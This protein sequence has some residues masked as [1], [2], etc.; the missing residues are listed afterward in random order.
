MLAFYVHLWP[1]YELLQKSVGTLIFCKPVFVVFVTE[2]CKSWFWF[3]D[4]HLASARMD[5]MVLRVVDVGF[6]NPGTLVTSPLG[7]VLARFFGR[8]C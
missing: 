1:T 2:K 8:A 7:E 5:S 4:V 3:H 6:I